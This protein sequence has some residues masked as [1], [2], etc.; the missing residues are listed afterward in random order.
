M[1]ELSTTITLNEATILSPNLCERFSEE[2]LT[3][4]GNFVWDGFDR[5][6]YSRSA[7]LRRNEAGMDL[8][9][10]MTQDK[11]WP[12][13]GCSNV[14]FPLVTVATMQFH[15]RAYPAL[16][17]P[18]SP[19]KCRVMGEQVPVLVERAHRV[20]NH[21]SFQLLEEDS[22]WEPQHDR[23]IFNYA[24]VGTAFKK[25][26]YD[27]AEDHP[28]SDLVL[29]KDFIVDYYAKSV[30]T[31]E[32]KTH[33]FPLPRNK[34]HSN[35]RKG[36]YRDVLSEGWYKVDAQPR[37]SAQEIMTARRKGQMPVTNDSAT[38][39]WGLEQHVLLDLDGDGYAEPYII[40]IEEKSRAVLR[41]VTGFDSDVD[42]IRNASGEI[43]SVQQKQYFTPYVFIPSPDG[44]VY[45]IGFGVFLGPLNESVNSIV[46]QLIDS[47][48]L[49]NTA[50]GFLGRG[51]KIRSGDTGFTPFGW[52]RV[53]ASG[54]DLRSSIVPLPVREPSN[55]MFQLLGLLI[56]YT[57][58]VA[59]ATDMQ[60]GENPG[61]NMKAQTAE[62]LVENGQ[63]VYAAIFKRHWRAFK[64]ELKKLYL[65][66]A[67]YMSSRKSYPQG[68]IFR[69]DYLGDANAIVPTA[70]PAVVSE[71]M[72]L[73]QATA[74]KQAAMTTPGYDLQAVELYYLES[75]KVEQPSRFY[76][77]PDK[78]PPL[79]NP[80]MQVEQA[81]MQ[82]AQ[83]KIEFE[84]FKF[85]GEMQETH[86]L[87]KA[88][89]QELQAMSLKLVAEAKGVETGHMIA[90]IEASIGAIRA[91]NDSLNERMRV[92]METMQ[93]D[94]AM[95]GQN[96]NAGGVPQVGQRPNDGGAQGG[97]PMGSGS[98]APAMG[99]GGLF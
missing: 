52:N 81:K 92:I 76:K 75:L 39:Y 94:K 62:L 38:P 80:K 30:E 16:L 25:T 15:S 35:V 10:Q 72:K 28:E 27:G 37:M 88:K 45:G 86:E 34:I 1:L 20:G 60:V 53:D 3:K 29:A 18:A 99:G 46:N 4:I 23:M 69:E 21:M 93:H 63:T 95:E 70:D 22:D 17:S 84:K 85:L 68:M 98:P 91:H 64:Q 5:D 56:D 89:I 83:A 32:R 2:D 8:A 33:R 41:I 49:A 51:A 79:P 73:R 7:W 61:Q 24:I 44:G 78:V 19:V 90:A 40:T 13:A 65:L 47:G 54:D 97:A 31:A 55:V 50:G 58:R 9:M 57:N 87:N 11:T 26:F 71:T 36:L 82:V 66:N 67:Q 96:A 59:G 14:A 77:G 42:I 12:W 6:E 48:T 43:V 74:L